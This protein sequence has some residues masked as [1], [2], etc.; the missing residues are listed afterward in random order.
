MYLSRWQIMSSFVL[1]R[2]WSRCLCLYSTVLREEK[3]MIL[4]CHCQASEEKTS[5]WQLRCWSCCMYRLGYG[6]PNHLRVLHFFGVFPVN[7]FPNISIWF[8]YVEKQQHW[9]NYLPCMHK[10]LLVCYSCHY[11]LKKVCTLNKKPSHNGSVLTYK[12]S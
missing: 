3:T 6:K 11:L 4:T 7:V 5:F 9:F 2:V 8:W 10:H 1:T 12:C